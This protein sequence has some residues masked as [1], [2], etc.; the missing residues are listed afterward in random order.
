MNVEF[1]SETVCRE[2]VGRRKSENLDVGTFLTIYRLLRCFI[3]LRTTE[4][5]TFFAIGHKYRCKRVAATGRV[6]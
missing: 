1:V 5:E 2:T 3:A 4:S 6:L